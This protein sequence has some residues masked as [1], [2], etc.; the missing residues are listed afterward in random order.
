[1]SIA[2]IIAIVAGAAAAATAAVAAAT[3]PQVQPVGAKAG[4]GKR[5]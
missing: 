3:R 4:K 5:Q 2:T 1:M